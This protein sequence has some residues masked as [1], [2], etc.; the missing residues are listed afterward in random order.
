ML[1]LLWLWPI[2]GWMCGF[3]YGSKPFWPGGPNFF[4]QDLIS[5]AFLLIVCGAVVG[6][7]G[8]FWLDIGSNE[9]PF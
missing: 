1:D 5:S 3:I 2:I 8:I 6:P 4:S 9:W 7:F